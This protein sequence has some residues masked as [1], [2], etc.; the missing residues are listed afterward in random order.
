MSDD[1]TLVLKANPGR[2]CVLKVQFKR[3][4]R[5]Y[6]GATLHVNGRPNEHLSYTHADPDQIRLEFSHHTEI[7]SLWVAS[8]CFEVS[9]DEAEKIATAFLPHGL[10]VHP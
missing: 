7:W 5:A 1:P 3:G 6:F 2:R 9:A 8:T 10:R 4:K